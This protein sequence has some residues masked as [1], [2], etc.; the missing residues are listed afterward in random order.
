MNITKINAQIMPANN[1]HNNQKKANVSFGSIGNNLQV[2]FRQNASELLAKDAD[3]Y[4]EVIEDLTRSHVM[5]DLLETKLYKD[6]ERAQSGNVQPSRFLLAQG[7]GYA[8]NAKRFQAIHSDS[9][10]NNIQSILDIAHNVMK[11][12]KAI[13]N[14]PNKLNKIEAVE[15]KI[16]VEKAKASKI[17]SDAI[18]EVLHFNEKPRFNLD[19]KLSVID[20]EIEKLNKQKKSLVDTSK[21]SEVEKLSELFPHKLE[22]NSY[23]GDKIVLADSPHTHVY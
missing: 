18:E 22:E 16:N 1:R 5:F 23:L 14:L 21:A 8:C 6:I 20:A 19:E 3:K 15:N 10:T 7:G 12:Y 9:W 2:F 4:I 11:K 13:D 17:K